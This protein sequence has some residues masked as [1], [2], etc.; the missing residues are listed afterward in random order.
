M[1]DREPVENA[2]HY[3]DIDWPEFCLGIRPEETT[4]SVL[5]STTSITQPAVSGGSPDAKPAKAKQSL[6]FSDLLAAI[7][8]IQHIPIVG[9]IYRAITGDTMSPTAEVVGG[10]LFGGIIGAVTSLADVVFAQATGKNV[11][12]TVLS[13]LGFDSNASKTQLA[14]ATPSSDFPVAPS[15]VSPAAGSDAALATQA[16][17]AYRRA[18]TLQTESTM[19]G[20]SLSY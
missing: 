10:A 17:F 2:A 7:N 15:S 6:G 16:A 11:G 5:P 9:S 13:W 8:P 14:K 20:L 3:L 1:R 12:D 4:L 18:S 19:P